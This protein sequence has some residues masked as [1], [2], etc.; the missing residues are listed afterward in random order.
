M[1]TGLDPVAH[2]GRGREPW[3]KEACRYVE[4]WG[5]RMESRRQETLGL[6]LGCGDC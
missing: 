5:G 3:K 1:A 4:N 2:A 6:Q